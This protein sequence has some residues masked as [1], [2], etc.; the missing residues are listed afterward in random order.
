MPA[1]LD[2]KDIQVL[3]EHISAEH[4]DP[5]VDEDGFKLVHAYMRHKHSHRCSM[6]DGRCQYGFPLRPEDKSSWDETN[7]RVTYRRRGM[8]AD[9]SDVVEHCPWLLR[10]YRTHINVRAVTNLA[11]VGYLFKYLFKPDTGDETVKARSTGPRDEGEEYFE[12]R[13]VTAS[14]AIWRI[15]Q[16][17]LF[18]RSVSV[19]TLPVHAP[20]GCP[21]FYPTGVSLAERAVMAQQALARNMLEQYFARPVQHEGLRYEEYFHRYMVYGGRSA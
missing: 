3:D 13:Y 15:L 16:F 5:S 20:G 12:V 9:D 7:D 19:I 4:P 2:L 10:K 14:E 8:Y 21:V 6:K 11:C 18:R 17:Y 1:G